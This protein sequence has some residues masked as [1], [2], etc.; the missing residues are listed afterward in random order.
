ML[1]LLNAIPAKSPVEYKCDACNTAKA[2]KNRNCDLS[3]WVK[4]PLDLISA[5]ICGAF[6][7]AKHWDEK[8]FLEAI[9][10]YTWRSIV[11]TGKTCTDVAE[12][13]FKWKKT[14]ELQTEKRLKAVRINNA[15][16]LESRVNEW[17]EES[18]VEVQSTAAYT[19]SQN[20]TAEQALQ[21]T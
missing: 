7:V 4:A 17:A 8:Y 10:N 15:K 11:F 5:D 19:S 14:A 6:P 20:G 16:E 21:S 2:K 12:Q 3:E 13:L 9:D 18:G 1:N